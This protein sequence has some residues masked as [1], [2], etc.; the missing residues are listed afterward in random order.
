MGD[1][2]AVRERGSYGRERQLGEGEAVR[3]MCGS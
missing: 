2:E 1:G 3:G